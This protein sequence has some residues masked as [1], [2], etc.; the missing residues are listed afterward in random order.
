L[1]VVPNT[2]EGL[3]R[4]LKPLHMR[5][6]QLINREKGWKG[7]LWQGRYFSSSMGDVYL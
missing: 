7:Y 2:E 5:Y 3:N 6:A 4:M 1:V